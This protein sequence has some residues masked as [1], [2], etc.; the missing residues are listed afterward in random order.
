MTTYANFLEAA[1]SST[2][3]DEMTRAM[4]VALDVKRHANWAQST[5]YT[6]VLAAVKAAHADEI[7]KEVEATAAAQRRTERALLAAARADFDAWVE[8]LDKDARFTNVLANVVR[9]A[10]RSVERYEEVN[11]NF[12][13]NFAQDPVY[14]LSWGGDLVEAATDMRVSK[15]VLS[16][17][18]AGSTEEQIAKFAMEQLLH[19]AKSGL[20]RST[21]MMSNLT[22]DATMKAWARV[23]ERLNGS[24]I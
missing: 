18:E 23:V 5:Y 15:E 1:A 22:E 4:G 9:A 3:T 11:A 2:V 10:K 16:A 13:K 7:K 8:S 6:K 24:W 19:G 17:F 14:A 20:S 21:S 12:Q